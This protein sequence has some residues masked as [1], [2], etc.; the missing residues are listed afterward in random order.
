M[1]SLCLKVGVAGGIVLGASGLAAEASGGGMVN[2][3][4][5]IQYG[6]LGLCFLMIVFNRIDA[7][8]MAKTLDR[9]DSE[10]TRQTAT[11]VNSIADITS[12]LTDRPCVIGESRIKDALKELLGKDKN[13]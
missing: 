4:A 11:F 7:G 5:L 12:A 1:N 3:E 13:G 2:P 8:R 9:K 6:A 10:L